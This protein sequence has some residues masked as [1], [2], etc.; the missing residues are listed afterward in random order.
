MSMYLAA[1]LGLLLTTPSVAAVRFRLQPQQLSQATQ[2]PSQDSPQNAAP[3]SP[4]AEP[5]QS[6]AEPQGEPS[7]KPQ[8][9]ATP[10]AAQEPQKAQPEAA[11]KKPA[12]PTRAPNKKRH[13]RKTSAN[14]STATPP[15]KVVRNGGTADPAVQLAPGISAEQASSQ[16][17]NTTQL[18]AATDANLKQI[19]SRPMNSSQQ[20]SV[21]QIRKYMEQAKAA[22]QAGDVQ[23][24][25]NLASKALLL[26]DD[27]AKQ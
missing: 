3:A 18:L 26:S 19:S 8:T 24:A 17:Q 12:S 11:A 4:S 16:R 14:N 9:T 25:Q 27:L 10:E 6:G 1:I 22:E 2:P 23:R 5:P 15:K 13:R 7:A 20:A 21:D